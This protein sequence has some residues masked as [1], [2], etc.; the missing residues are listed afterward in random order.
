MAQRRDLIRPQYDGL[1]VGASEHLE[2]FTLQ[3]A[4]LV[5]AEMQ[6]THVGE[7]LDEYET[8]GSRVHHRL[9]IVHSEALEKLVAQ[10]VVTQIKKLQVELFQVE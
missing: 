7:V 8:K 3:M 5:V 1:H 9:L 2:M 10:C 4:Q 6:Q